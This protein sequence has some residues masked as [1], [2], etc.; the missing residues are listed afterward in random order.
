MKDPNRVEEN[1]EIEEPWLPIE[2]KLVVA[3]VVGGIIATIVFA[4]L[5]HMW[6]L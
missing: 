2:T 5:V 3:S 4:I 1:H 6:I